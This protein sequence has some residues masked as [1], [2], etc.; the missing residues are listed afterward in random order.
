MA[1]R[2]YVSTE[3]STDPRVCALAEDHGAFAALLY[4][5]M[6]PHSDDTG[7]LSDDPRKL[8]MLVVPG[9]PV[10][11]SEVRDALA[12]MISLGLL[13]HDELRRKLV[14]PRADWAEI[15]RTKLHPLRVAWNLIRLKVSPIVFARDGY[16]CRHCGATNRLEVDHIIPIARGGENSFDNYQTL[17]RPCN[18]RKWAH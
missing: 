1:R 4:T 12:T 11:V 18:R 15:K 13:E 10:K 8:R 2:R 14:F 3:I 6:I 7:A 17:C 5:W 16:K 9:L